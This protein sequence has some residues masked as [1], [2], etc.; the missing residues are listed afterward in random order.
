MWICVVFAFFP[1]HSLSLLIIIAGAGSAPWVQLPA[2]SS[3][4]GG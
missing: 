1:P 4:L 2:G 3:Q